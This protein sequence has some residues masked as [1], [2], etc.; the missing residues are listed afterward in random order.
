M[1]FEIPEDCENILNKIHL[2]SFSVI[3]FL[4]FVSWLL[5]RR[6]CWSGWGRKTKFDMIY[7]W[8]FFFKE[9]PW[10][11][12]LFHMQITFSEGTEIPG[13]GQ[14]MIN[15]C[16]WRMMMWLGLAATGAH[17]HLL[18]SQFTFQMQIQVLIIKYRNHSTFERKKTFRRFSSFPRF[19]KEKHNSGIGKEIIFLI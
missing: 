1:K 7:V 8:L 19:A 3:N 9:I 17:I 18:I 10:N 6:E 5:K 14:Q 16:E 2:T 15:G 12:I 4:S 11:V 13:D